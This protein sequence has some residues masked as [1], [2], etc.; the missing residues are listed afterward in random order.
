[1]W[2]VNYLGA[3]PAAAGIE[4]GSKGPLFQTARGRIALLTGNAMRR[5]DGLA[6]VK[7]RAEKG[8]PPLVDLQ[9]LVPRNRH[10]HPPGK[11]RAARR[12]AGA[13]RAC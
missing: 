3:Y 7:R 2:P 8:G 9:S 12:F 5:T 1:M 4:A 10:H 6:M 13:G 11:W